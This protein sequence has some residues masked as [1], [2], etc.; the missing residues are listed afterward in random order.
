[1]SR[2]EFYQ[3][4]VFDPFENNTYLN[5]SMI[6][7]KSKWQKS[8]NFILLGFDSKASRFNLQSL[9]VLSVVKR[10]DR[11]KARSHLLGIIF[12]TAYMKHINYTLVRFQSYMKS[13]VEV[14]KNTITWFDGL[15]ETYKFY[16]LYWILQEYTNTWFNFKKPF[17]FLDLHV[18]F[19]E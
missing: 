9:S 13:N 11:S 12:S 3:P 18:T 6:L 15:Y 7:K 14:Y 4:R 10:F 1:V 8:K 17:F 16:I 2:I 19:F 5:L